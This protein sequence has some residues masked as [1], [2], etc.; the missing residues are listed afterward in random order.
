M[1]LGFVSRTRRDRCAVALHVSPAVGPLPVASRL[2]RLRARIRRAFDLHASGWSRRALDILGA[3]FG[4]VLLAPLFALVALAIV[5]DD[6]GPVLFAQ[7]RVGRGGRPFRMWKF[8]SMCVDAERRLAD[9]ASDDGNAIRKKL[10]RDPRFTRIGALLRR[11]SIDE[12]PQLWNVLRGDMALVGPR[13]P[14][15]AEVARYDELAWR[16]LE[17]KPGLTCRWQ[18][19]GRADVPFEQQVLLDIDYALHRGLRRDLGL[20][21]RTV[22]AVLVGRGAY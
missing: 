21:L 20:I 1:I 22:P 16:R 11:T 15:P 4:L 8:R 13:P 9:L 7:P 17:L 10:R 18:V 19:E 3:S 12:L 5:L 14:I 6:R 2:W